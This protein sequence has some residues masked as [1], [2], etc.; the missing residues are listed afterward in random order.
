M[1]GV[2]LAE[3]EHGVSTFLGGDNGQVLVWSFAEQMP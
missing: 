1:D 2:F 3:T